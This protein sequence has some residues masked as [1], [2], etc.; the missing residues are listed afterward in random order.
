MKSVGKNIKNTKI[1]IVGI[2][3]K[4]N[5]ETSDTREST[6]LWFIEYLISKG[7]KNL[8]GYDPIIDNSELNNLGLKACSLEEGFKNS[9]AVFFM[10][11]HRSFY[12]LDIEPLLSLMKDSSYFFAG[13]NIFNISD[14]V[15]HPGIT[16]S[17]IGLK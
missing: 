13:W 16:Y 5:P 3:F 11:N 4:G 15:S 14:V 2:A 12:T 10:N 1:F 8:W 6:T 9:D 17:G 7:V